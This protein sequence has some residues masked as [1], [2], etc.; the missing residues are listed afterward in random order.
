MSADRTCTANFTAD[1]DLLIS[2]ISGPAVAAPGATIVLNNTVRNIGL[3]AGAFNVGLYI[4]SSAAVTT[5]DRQLTTRRVTGGLATNAI[6]ADATS[7]QIPSD[8]TPGNYF[9]GAIA[10]IDNEVPAEGNENN[11]AA[12]TPIVI[13]K[14]D[15]VVTVLTAPA[16]AGAGLAITIN[17]TVKNQATAAVTAAA[18]TL[19]FYLS[20]DAI[21][22]P[23]D[24]RLTATRAIPT[25]AKDAVS[26]GATTLTIP[27]GIA[28]GSY[29]LIA[30]AD[31]LS[32]VDESNEANNTRT[33][34][35]AIS[36]PDLSVTSVTATPTLTAAGMNVSITQIVRN[37]ATSPANAPGLELAPDVVGPRHARGWRR[38]RSRHGGDPRAGGRHAGDGHQERGDS[39]RHRDPVATGS[40]RARTMATS[41]PRAAGRRQQRRAHRATHHDRA[42]P[43]RVRRH[44]RR[45]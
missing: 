5:A 35:I 45:R 28:A 42:R 18:S 30:V 13:A 7:V 39:R 25:L 16:T 14:P 21:F 12:S 6:S 10:D 32:A 9:L 24:V 8:V 33:A 38:R 29:F 22:D 15:L 17:S 26:A 40:S 20:A 36:R 44:R 1:P 2:A 23:G 19:A 27:A 31:D 37:V 43:H 41:S 11:N 3:P 4:S 34:P